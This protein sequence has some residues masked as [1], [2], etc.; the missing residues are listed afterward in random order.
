MR[1][2]IGAERGIGWD[3]IEAGPSPL[4]ERTYEQAPSQIFDTGPSSD[5]ISDYMVDKPASLYMCCCA[6]PRPLVLSLLA[7]GT[8]RDR[9]KRRAIISGDDRVGICRQD[10]LYLRRPLA[11]EPGVGRRVI[12]SSR[13]AVHRSH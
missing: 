3:M 10:L 13:C 6:C 7:E 4:A 5:D 11:P 12:S 2:S 8:K 9:D 1:S